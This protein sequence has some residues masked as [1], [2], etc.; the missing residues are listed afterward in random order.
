MNIKKSNKKDWYFFIKK[1]RVAI[2]L[3]LIIV[4]LGYICIKLLPQEIYP[5]TSTPV[6]YVSAQYTGASS[7]IMETT[8]AN[9]IEAGLTGLDNLEYMQSEC[10]D[11]YYS[12]SIYFKAGSN[13]DVNLL[14]VKNQLQ[15][16]DFQ[17]PPEVQKEGV[18]A[19]TTSGEKG[20]IILNLS[21]KNDTWEQLDLANYA[22]SNIVDR[23][24]MVN[25]VAD[26]TLSGIGDYSMRIW[27]DPQKM[28]SLGV[29]VNDINYA[30]N[31][32]NGQFVIGTLGTPPLDTP[33][34]R[35]MLIKSDNLLAS[36]KDFENV[37][38]RSSSTHG[39][40]LLKDVARIE[41]GSSD[42]SSYAMVGTKTTALIQI[43]PTAGANMVELSNDI[44]KKVKQINKWLPHGLELSVI[45]DNAI[46]M[47]ESINEVIQTIFITIIIVMLV[48][49][50]FLGDWVSTMVPCVTIPISLI[51]AFGILYLFHMSINLLTL[52]ALILAVSVVVDDAIVV[53]E[54][55][56]RHLQEG[57]SP[58]RA[59][60]LTIEEV[61]VTLVTMAIILMTVFFPICFIPGFT[62]I[63]Y[64]Q[65]AVF[66]SAA[67]IISAVCALTLSPAMTSVMMSKT[68]D[69]EKFAQGKL[70]LWSKCFY[71]F[72]KFFD[73]L[74]QIYTDCVKIFVYNPK[75]TITTYLCVLFLMISIFSIIPK[76]FVPDEDQGIVFG[77]V[78]LDNSSTIQKSKN[79]VK[80]IMS[81]ISNVEGLD[82]KKIL[83]IGSETNATMYIQLKNWKDRNLNIIQKIKRK[84]SK[85]QDDLSSLGIQAVLTEVTDNID[86]IYVNITMPSALGS[87][88]DNGFEFNL[89]SMGNYKNEQLSQY[90]DKIV[91][92]LKHNKKIASAYNTYYG[93]VPMYILHIDYKKALALNI[94]T[95]ELTSTLASFIGSTNV[96]NFTKNGKNY[97][98]RMQADGKFRRDKNDLN[99]IYVRSNTGIMIPVGAVISLEEVQSAPSISRFNQNRSICIYAQKANGVSAG[100][101]IQEMENVAK[102]I[103]P[104]DITYEWSGSSLQVLE[105]S[106]QTAFIIALALLFIYFFLVALYNSWSIPAVIL[107]VSPVSIVG[108]LVFLLMLGKPFDLYSQ[109]GV[110]TLIGL[111]A[112]QSILFVEF[113][114]T[115]KE[116]NNV[117]VQNASILAANMR[118]R[119]ILMTELSFLIGV[120][121]MLF[122]TGPSANSRISL[123]ATVFGGM[124]TTVS[125]GAV[126]TPGFYAI[127]QGFVDKLPK[128][129][130]EEYYQE[131]DED[132]SYEETFF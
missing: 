115:Q 34:E 94:S 60:Q 87:G 129:V 1:T 27:L 13:K 31:E 68:S 96:S 113:A 121:P 11:G 19:I 15:E 41:L 89:I 28:A 70:G 30:L 74:S 23:L 54:N 75:I 65:F 108:A 85:Q 118:F 44:E 39:Q 114:M 42:Y 93:T 88:T 100:E 81:K 21:S 106:R 49:L 124:L 22:K 6:V 79:S 29:T 131:N 71:L 110:I 47:K 5:D 130:E 128:A 45:Y 35:Q 127:I 66:L 120:I 64:K 25:G 77:S 119:A 26:A 126:L 52:F 56:N 63:L 50:L 95:Q 8:V 86:D 92:K 80:K 122:A 20:A 116:S 123:A 12:L 72:N 40:V 46:Y 48:I 17:L 98:V 90:A 32:Q 24:K 103:L 82:L 9:I 37:V 99:K 101:A 102:S 105:S 97:E 73:K 2:V 4:V 62:G 132:A 125:V 84:I 117:S 57:N 112:K 10:M 91:E 78:Y 76:T 38:I 16:I 53:V 59:T 14:N 33:Q 109:I 111:A 58:K 18:S 107:I 51:G 7:S 3:S 83:I 61:G 55:V 43:I 36:A 67:I 69:K 104:S